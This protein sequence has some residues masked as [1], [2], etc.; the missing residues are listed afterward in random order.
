M[1]FVTITI[2]STA[3]VNDRYFVRDSG[4]KPIVIEERGRAVLSFD[5][6]IVFVFSKSVGAR[7]VCSEIAL[8][9]ATRICWDTILNRL[10]AER[11]YT[12]LNTEK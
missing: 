1:A 3:I 8:P 10:K 2:I 4:S 12:T 5:T 6:P 9:S 11:N 7:R